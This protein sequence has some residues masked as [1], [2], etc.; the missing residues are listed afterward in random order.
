MCVQIESD[1]IKKN[2]A[3]RGLFRIQS[4]S[5][6]GA[7]HSLV[8]FDELWGYNSEN[9]RRLFE[10]LTPP[11]TERDAWMLIA[12]YDGFT[13]EST[14]LETL[15]QRGLAGTRVDDALEVTTPNA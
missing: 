14:L 2:P 6:A 3:L 15:Y 13:E 12:S 9:L 7:R 8:V 1:L 4:E 11:A 5:S 10:E